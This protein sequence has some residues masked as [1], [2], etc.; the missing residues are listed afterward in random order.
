MPTAFEVFRLAGNAA[1]RTGWAHLVI[2]GADYGLYALTEEID[3]RFAARWFE[4]ADAVIHDG[5]YVNEPGEP[6]ALVDF[7]WDT[8]PMWDQEGGPVDNTVLADVTTALD[9]WEAGARQWADLDDVIDRATWLRH[10]AAEEW[11][12]HVDGYV[13]MPN[14]EWLVTPDDG[15]TRVVAWDTDQAFLHDT[16]WFTGT[17]WTDPGGRLARLCRQDPACDAEWEATL[18]GVALRADTSDLAGL[19]DRLDALTRDAALADPRR[20]CPADAVLPARDGVRA[21]LAGRTAELD[22]GE[23]GRAHV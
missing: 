12:G 11:A 4:D 22:A 2:D 8:L 5:S 7:T 13:L 20:E 9:A 18:D 17:R 15:R 21:W 3:D 19:V 10:L 23:I 14:N 6:L 1:P 16:D